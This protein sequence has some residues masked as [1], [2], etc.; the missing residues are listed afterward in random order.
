MSYKSVSLFAVQLVL[1]LHA[2][3]CVS[4][5]IASTHSGNKGPEPCALVCSGTTGAGRTN[6]RKWATGEIYLWVDTSD[7]GFVSKPTVTTTLS[8]AVI[9]K[10]ITGTSQVAYESTG[11][12]RVYLQG[13]VDENGDLSPE[14]AMDRNYAVNW[15]AVGYNC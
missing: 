2:A 15:L 1:L 6:W 14:Y 12:F 7:C 11:G 10:R 5:K 3:S 13:F 8:V 4:T 9:S